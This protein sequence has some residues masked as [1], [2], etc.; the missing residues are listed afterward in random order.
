VSGAAEIFIFFVLDIVFDLKKMQRACMVGA[1]AV[2]C[3][4][5]AAANL[6]VCCN[7]ARSVLLLNVE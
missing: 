3:A 2:E 4:M 1:S 7:F 5:R 6:Q